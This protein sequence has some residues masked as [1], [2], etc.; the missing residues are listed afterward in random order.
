LRIKAQGFVSKAEIFG[1]SKRIKGKVRRRI[2]KMTNKKTWQMN[3][4]IEEVEGR[5]GERIGRA[6]RKAKARF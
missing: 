2:G 6:M 5:A 3:G 1:R 4:I